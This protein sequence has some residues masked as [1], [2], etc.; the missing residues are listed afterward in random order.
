MIETLILQYLPTLIAVLSS[1][2]LVAKALSIFNKIK[3]DVS[4]N[5]EYNDVKNQLA[6]CLQQNNELKRQ[7][8]DLLEAIEHIR[9]D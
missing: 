4:V 7:V 6:I 1:I 5:R 9:R 3:N 8:K 2:G